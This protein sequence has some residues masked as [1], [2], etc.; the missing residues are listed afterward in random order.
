M[1][2]NQEAANFRNHWA[3]GI[4]ILTVTAIAGALVS[5]NVSAHSGDAT[6]VHACVNDTTAQTLIVSPGPGIQTLIVSTCPGLWAQDGA[7]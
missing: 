4:G 5:N 7:P 6:V 2:F 3:T 1:N